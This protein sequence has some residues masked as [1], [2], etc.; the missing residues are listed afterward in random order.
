MTA[1]ATNKVSDVHALAL[2]LE[3]LRRAANALLQAVEERNGN[4]DHCLSELESAHA[5]SAQADCAYLRWA[6]DVLDGKEKTRRKPGRRPES[7]DA[8]RARALKSNIVVHYVNTF[9]GTQYAVYMDHKKVANAM[10][11]ERCI[12]ILRKLMRERKEQRR[13]KQ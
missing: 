10:T 3:R 13:R 2:A 6:Q 5:S 9:E 12:V 4:F 7:F 11:G 8:V 1:A